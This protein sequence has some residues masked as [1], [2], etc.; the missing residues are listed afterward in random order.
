LVEQLQI[1]KLI[2]HVLD[3][4]EELTAEAMSFESDLAQL[5]QSILAKAFRGELV[6]QDPNDEP[7]SELLARIRKQ[8]DEAIQKK[9]FRPR[10]GTKNNRN[11]RT[12]T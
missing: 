6:P 8:Q 10:N 11:E 7:A 4:R 2:K 3:R 9:A 5:D 12:A 1:A